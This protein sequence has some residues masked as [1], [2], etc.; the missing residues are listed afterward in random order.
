M[1]YILYNDITEKQSMPVALHCV[2]SLPPKPDHQNMSKSP[3][4]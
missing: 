2:M 4:K 3:Q 1:K